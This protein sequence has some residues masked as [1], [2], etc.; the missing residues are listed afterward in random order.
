VELVIRATIIFWVLWLIVRGTGKRTL[1]EL[2]PF[3][4][5][6]FFVMGDIVQQ[7]V[8]QED[9][10]VTGSTI[11]VGT[12]AMWSVLVSMFAYRSRV[13]RRVLDGVPLVVVRDGVALADHMRLDRV[14]RED[15]DEAARNQGIDNLADV[16]LALLEPDGRFS[17]LKRDPDGDDDQNPE[18]ERHR[19]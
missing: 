5:I 13:G 10:S 18:V 15:L 9:M 4:L 2:S 1:A 19:A 7:G 12:I 6:L 8:T 16:R 17:F 3:E 11:A 14:A